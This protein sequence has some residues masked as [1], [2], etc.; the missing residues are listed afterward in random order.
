MPD[1]I[2]TA[3]GS[4]DKFVN[5]TLTFHSF[6]FVVGHGWAIFGA[7]AFVQFGVEWWAALTIILHWPWA[8]AT[9]RM[10]L[11]TAPFLHIL[12]ITPGATSLAGPVQHQIEETAFWNNN[13]GGRPVAPLFPFLLSFWVLSES[14]GDQMADNSLKQ[15]LSSEQM[16]QCGGQRRHVPSSAGY[17]RRVQ[18]RLHVPLSRKYPSA[19][20]KHWVLMLSHVRQE[21]SQASHVPSGLS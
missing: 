7:R 3:D 5:L 9:G 18:L 11:A 16:S 20:D 15:L 6:I 1:I 13:I 12:V 17:I 10:A 14:W 8:G 2:N 4:Q 19:H 21:L